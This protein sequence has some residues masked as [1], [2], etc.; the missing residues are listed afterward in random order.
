MKSL[1]VNADLFNQ[2]ILE[3]VIPGIKAKIPHWRK[4]EKF[5]IQMDNAR[6]HSQSTKVQ[7]IHKALGSGGWN[8]EIRPQPAQSPD[9]NV[10]DLCLFNSMQS[11]QAKQP[12][13]NIRDAVNRI[14]EVFE[15]YCPEKLDNS[16]ITL[17]A[18]M[19]LVFKHEGKNDYKLPHLGKDKK[20]RAGDPMITFPI[21]DDAYLT[22]M[23]AMATL[24]LK[25]Q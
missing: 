6:P 21:C 14:D 17:Q 1:N 9:L 12:F 23:S 16:F 10:L 4:H 15:N 5:F 18:V 7:E 20:K 13:A 2:F 24:Q 8:L 22:G 11:M 19:Q 3:K 25:L